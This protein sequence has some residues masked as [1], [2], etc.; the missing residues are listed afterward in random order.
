MITIGMTLTGYAQIEFNSKFKA[1]P[2]KDNAP[3]I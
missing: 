2:T 1:I 3:K